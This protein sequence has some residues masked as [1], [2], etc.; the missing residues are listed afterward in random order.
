M[1]TWIQY[2]NVFI[3]MDTVRMIAKKDGKPCFY[4][5]HTENEQHIAFDESWEEF[6]D[7]IRHAIESIYIRETVHENSESADAPMPSIVVR[8]LTVSE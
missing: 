2:C 4:F 5:G 6:M 3:N 1:A 8:E 7:R